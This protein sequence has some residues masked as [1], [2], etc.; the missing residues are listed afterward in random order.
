MAA[1]NA[2]KENSWLRAL[3]QEIGFAF[4][5]PTTIHCDNNAAI[6]L[7]ED[8]LLHERVKHIDIKY[9]FLR[10]RAESGELKLHYINTKDNLADIFTKALEGAQL[11]CLCG[12]L[13]LCGIQEQA[14]ALR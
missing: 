2:A 13:G 6:C 4:S 8:P 12:L 7:S 14:V 9:H 10:E 3:F 5:D 11:A 1:F